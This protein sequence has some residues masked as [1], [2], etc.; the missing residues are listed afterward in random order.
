MSPG[1]PPQLVQNGV[2]AGAGEIV[3]DRPV[4]FCPSGK[5]K[6]LAPAAFRFATIGTWIN[7]AS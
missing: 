5:G 3:I 6:A 4:E 1:K 7:L 2:L